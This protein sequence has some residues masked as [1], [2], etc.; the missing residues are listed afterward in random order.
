MTFY[1][2]HGSQRVKMH[3][4]CQFKTCSKYIMYHIFELSGGVGL[5]AK[6]IPLFV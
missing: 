5:A 3:T 2:K 4:Y 1:D 6:A